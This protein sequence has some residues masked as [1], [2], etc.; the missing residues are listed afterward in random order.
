MKAYH[1]RA[2]LVCL[3]RTQT[4]EL[5]LVAHYDGR[6]ERPRIVNGRLRWSRSTPKTI[7][8][9]AAHAWRQQQAIE[10]KQHAAR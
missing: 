10:R 8:Q 4:G 6:H 1:C 9:A 7:R 3:H 2:G 5:V